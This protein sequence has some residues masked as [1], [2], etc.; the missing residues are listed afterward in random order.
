[1]RLLDRVQRALEPINH[2]RLGG[3]LL[4]HVLLEACGHLWTRELKQ[5][6]VRDRDM[7]VHFAGRAH[8]R[9]R[10]PCEFLRRSG[11]G[12][13]DQLPRNVQPLAVVALPYA[14]EGILGE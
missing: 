8:A 2:F 5:V 14:F 12:E 7:H 3:H 10:T 11:F 6:E 13:R 4:F 9:C 1:M